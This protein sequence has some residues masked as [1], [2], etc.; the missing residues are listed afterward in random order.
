VL[1]ERTIES[2]IEAIV[3]FLLK[4]KA[5]YKLSMGEHSHDIILWREYLPEEPSTSTLNKPFAGSIW[6]TA[7]VIYSLLGA[8]SINELANPPPDGGTLLD[9]DF[10]VKVANS[11][12][13]VHDL[14]QERSNEEFDIIVKAISR[15]QIR[16]PKLLK[17]AL[18]VSV[19]DLQSYIGMPRS[20]VVSDAHAEWGTA[21]LGVTALVCRTFR[22]LLK[23]DLV[24]PDNKA[25]EIAFLKKMSNYCSRAEL[26]ILRVS[27][28]E[29]KIETDDERRTTVTGGTSDG[30]QEAGE[31]ARSVLACFSA[32]AGK[33]VEKYRLNLARPKQ[34]YGESDKEYVSYFAEYL[35][36][37]GPNTHGPGCLW[38]SADSF[39]WSLSSQNLVT[40]PDP[41]AVLPALE[42][43]GSAFKYMDPA[44]IKKL[45]PVIEFGVA[46]FGAFLS[47]ENDSVNVAG[48]KNPADL[49]PLKKVE[50]SERWAV[51]FVSRQVVNLINV[52]DCFETVTEEQCKDFASEWSKITNNL[53]ACFQCLYAALLIKTYQATIE[54][55]G[56]PFEAVPQELDAGNEFA[57]S[58]GV[59]I[60]FVA[61]SLLVGRSRFRP[62]AAT[63]DYCQ[64]D[65]YY[66]KII[67]PVAHIPQ[68]LPV[69][70][71]IY[72]TLLDR[73]CERVLTAYELGKEDSPMAGGF[74]SS[75]SDPKHG[76]YRATVYTWA[77]AHALL[78]LCE[79]KRQNP[80][81]NDAESKIKLQES[82]HHNELLM[83]LGSYVA[84][85]G[86]PAIDDESRG[87]S[88]KYLV[89]GSLILP[90]VAFGNLGFTCSTTIQDT[91]S[92][93]WG[94]IFTALTKLSVALLLAVAVFIFL[95]REYRWLLKALKTIDNSTR[96][97]RWCAVRRQ[98]P[99]LLRKDTKCMFDSTSTLNKCIFHESRPALSDALKAYRWTYVILL[100]LVLFACAAI[101]F[102]SVDQWISLISARVWAILTVIGAVALY[103]LNRILRIFVGKEKIFSWLRPLRMCWK[104]LTGANDL[105]KIFEL[106]SVTPKP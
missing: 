57:H 87:R 25:A 22:L 82:L 58:P 95:F 81:S 12:L 31:L 46:S 85:F 40:K 105:D 27:I 1:T 62:K 100:V 16:E 72:R 92:L 51:E 106:Q 5:M 86:L 52:L 74:L 20:F 53:D 11:L 64:F 99:C 73:V 91:L 42:I 34:F 48:L 79:W 89:A 96:T 59:D 90:L 76:Q 75:Y 13:A 97:S 19:K 70:L 68:Q 83:N 104:L 30:M 7:D 28:R 8:R 77:T 23:D 2:S 71:P 60:S 15:S 93:D 78:A 29:T 6:S 50:I 98:G 101:S 63:D 26:S 67:G 41:M 47:L 69:T 39:G 49:S 4:Q 65:Q 18:R 94:L 61:Y 3:A 44:S 9:K 33:V 14:I 17:R 21:N 102:Q 103:V 56:L 55:H 45:L 32:H 35:E 38:A 24:S 36:T 80:S 88:S 10:F 43:I 84:G 66:K 37:F 54:N